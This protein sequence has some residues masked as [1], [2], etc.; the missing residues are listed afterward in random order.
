MM[1]YPT[2][3]SRAIANDSLAQST[4]L[5][6]SHSARCSSVMPSPSWL[7]D[8]QLASLKALVMR[9]PDPERDGVSTWRAKNLCQLVLQRFGVSYTENGMLRLSF[10]K[11]EDAKPRQIQISGVTEGQSA[12]VTSGE[13]AAA[14]D[15]FE[16]AS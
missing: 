11:V 7:D 14:S 6:A 16:Q 2:S 10:P 13:P 8:G 5:L 1:Q 15:T 9:G 4:G 12:Q 3:G